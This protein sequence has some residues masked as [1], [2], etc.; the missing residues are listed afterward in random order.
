MILVVLA[1]NVDVKYAVYQDPTQS[2]ARLRKSHQDMLKE[3]H[4]VCPMTT[5]R[6]V[7]TAIYTFPLCDR[8]SI[9]H[10]SLRTA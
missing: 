5:R 1:A 10:I 4:T 2:F 6:L 7:G 8:L 9:Q 3:W